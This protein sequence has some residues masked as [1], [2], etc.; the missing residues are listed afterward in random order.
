MLL[1]LEVHKLYIFKMNNNHGLNELL[2]HFRNGLLC[3]QYILGQ[4]AV[5]FGPNWFLFW[6]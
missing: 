5:R 2:F 1:E 3:C 6:A 4:N